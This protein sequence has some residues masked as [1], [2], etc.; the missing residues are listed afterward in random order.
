MQIWADA[1]ACP[2][3]IKKNLYRAAKRLQIHL[4]LVANASIQ[5]PAFSCIES[6]QVR[7][8]LDVADNYIVQQ[9][10]SWRPCHYGRYPPGSKRD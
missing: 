7:S 3:I 9:Y 2:N 8:G 1:D 5:I 6:V 4:T 10:G